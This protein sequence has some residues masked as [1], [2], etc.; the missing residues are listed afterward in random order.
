VPKELC[1]EFEQLNLSI[2]TNTLELEVAPTLKK[3]THKSQ[4][5]D[6]NIMVIVELIIVGKPLGITM[7]DMGTIWYGK[8]MCMPSIKSIYENHILLCFKNN[9]DNQII[10]D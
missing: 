10:V 2:I 6:E 3:D 5:E 9:N 1:E 7:D 8:R 4:I